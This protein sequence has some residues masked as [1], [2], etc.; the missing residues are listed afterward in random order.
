MSQSMQLVFLE[1]LALVKSPH[2]DYLSPIQESCCGLG[3]APRPS[4]S[5][6]VDLSEKLKEPVARRELVNELKGWHVH[7][8]V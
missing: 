1:M 3:R 6:Q 5:S 2:A 7:F 4:S 8:C